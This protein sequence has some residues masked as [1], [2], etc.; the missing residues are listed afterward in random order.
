MQR[1]Q[2]AAWGLS[3]ATLASWS[4]VA[5]G[6]QRTSNS[7]NSSNDESEAAS[8]RACAKACTDCQRECDSCAMHCGHELAQGQ[9]R[10]HYTT[11]RTCLDCADICAA[12]AQIM[13]RSGPFSGDICEACA[14]ACK[15]CGE[16][17]KQHAGD[18]MMQNCAA[19]CERCEKACRDMV[20]AARQ[21][22]GQPQR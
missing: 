5:G 4:Q 15:R 22:S 11:L 7:A 3:A 8:F 1:R 10:D 20:R 13:S 17:C 2:F 18:K 14:D 9:S 19:E 12:A 6:Q 16:A 21:S